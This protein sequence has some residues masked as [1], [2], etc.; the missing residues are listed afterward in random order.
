[1]DNSKLSCSAFGLSLIGKQI[2]GLVKILPQLIYVLDLQKRKIVFISDRITDILGYSK[3]DI[4]QM[5]NSLGPIMVHANMKDF[6]A[7][8]SQKFDRIAIGENIEFTMAFRH[9]NGQIRTLKNTAN[10]LQQNAEGKNQYIMLIAEDITEQ[11]LREEILQF[12]QFHLHN[13]ERVFQYG[14]WE[15]EEGSEY[16]KWTD[17]LFELLGVPKER[18]PDRRVPVDFYSSFIPPTEKDLVRA[19]VYEKIEAK[20]PYH[21]ISHSII[22][23]D[24][25]TKYVILRM[26]IFETN[27]TSIIMGT[28]V[29]NT[30]SM[31]AEKEY[32]DQ[33]MQLQRQHTQMEE[34]EAI[35]KF[36][37]WE[38]NINEA[39]FRWSEGLFNLLE[40]DSNQYPQ[41]IVPLDFYPSF[42]HPEDVQRVRDYTRK[43]LAEQKG[44]YE[45]EHRIIDSTGVI[46]NVMLRARV[47]YDENG[48]MLRAVGV[49]ADLTE[50]ETYRRELERQVAALNRSNQELEQFA[51]VASHDLQEP[52]RKIKAFGERLEKKYKD[53]VGEEG[54]FFIDRM[55]N[56]AQRMNTLIDD[57]LTYS[58]ASRET[59]TPKQIALNEV[60]KNVIDDLEIKIQNENAQISVGELPMIEAQGVQMQQLFQNLIEN[61][62]KFKKTDLSPVV[63]ISAE[64]VSK[65]DYHKIPQLNQ[66]LEYYRFTISD[67]GIGFDARYADQIF[68][69]FQRLHGRTEYEGTG[70]GLAICRKIVESHSGYI[71]AKG[72]EGVGAT[73][74]F[75]L[76]TTK[77]K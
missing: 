39:H 66:S 33:M 58:R 10:L 11:I 62:L 46:K 13:S 38:C 49:T 76:P 50:I 35:F 27:K 17:G 25:E 47:Q 21:E 30:I 20:I 42:V 40:L 1:M 72:E 3:Q 55:I 29:D 19:E 8:I 68:A 60:V 6:A 64:K 59:E 56:A 16:V 67:N 73:F 52:L 18:F 9:K 24:G 31:K 12:K 71:M 2:E 36:G 51:Y 54:G 7:D 5:G 26:H 45:I 32:N 69:I 63:H 77:N 48:R 41:S 70:L 75:Y 43:V 57:L 74:I 15:M 14:S 37:S 4:E 61:A 44:F 22:S 28:V 34:A 23:L 53:A 65:I